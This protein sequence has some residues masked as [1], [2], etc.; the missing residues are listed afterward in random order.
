[1][2]MYALFVEEAQALYKFCGGIV[3]KSIKKH[4]LRC[5]TCKL[6]ILLSYNVNKNIWILTLSLSA[7]SIL[8]TSFLYDL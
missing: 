8:P 2:E 4:H 7:G 3:R 6:A 5:E 1:M